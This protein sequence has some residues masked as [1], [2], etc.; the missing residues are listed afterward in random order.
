[1]VHLRPEH[2]RRQANHDQNQRLR[3]AK[4]TNETGTDPHPELYFKV[5]AVITLQATP[6]PRN[7]AGKILTHQ[8]EDGFTASVEDD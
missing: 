8:L 6:L 7:A 2:G 1:L 5:S 4:L 3:F